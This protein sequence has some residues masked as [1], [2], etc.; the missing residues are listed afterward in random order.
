VLKEKDHDKCGGPERRR[1]PRCLAERYVS[2]EFCPDPL[3]S[4]YLF[5]IRDESASG[6]GILIKEGSEA[7]KHLRVGDVLNITCR[8]PRPSESLAHMKTQ[9]MHVTKHDEGQFKGHYLVGLAIIEGQ[10]HD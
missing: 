6:L 3:E 9:I 8:G 1:E 7:L 5:R 2:V 4:V 10:L